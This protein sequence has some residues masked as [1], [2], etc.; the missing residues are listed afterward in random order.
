MSTATAVRAHPIP[1]DDGKAQA[2]A[3]KLLGALNNSALILM[4]SIGHRTGLFDALAAISPCT[5]LE[6]AAEADLGPTSFPPSTP[7]G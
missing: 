2:F 6:L 3:G 5:A 7:P 4:T 1:F